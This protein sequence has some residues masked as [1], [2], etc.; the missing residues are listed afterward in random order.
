MFDVTFTQAPD[1]LR[2]S[3][4]GSLDGATAPRLES[5]L[6][7][8][9]AAAPAGPR[10]LLDLERLDFVSSAGLRVFLAYAKKVG[11]AGG[12]LVLSGLRPVPREVFESSGFT[13]IFTIVPDIAAGE[14]ALA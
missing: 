2:V 1:H 4:H 9:L 3:L 6:A 12:R 11:N 14:R 10:W 7:A 13:R 5:A 8:R